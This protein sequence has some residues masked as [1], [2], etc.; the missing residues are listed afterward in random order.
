MKLIRAKPVADGEFYFQRNARG[1]VS[2]NVQGGG[3]LR[4][5]GL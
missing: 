2:G 3:L 5:G 4:G 1:A